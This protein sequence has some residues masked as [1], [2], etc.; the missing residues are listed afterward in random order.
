VFVSHAPHLREKARALR[1]ERD[2]TIDEIAARL[3]LSRTTVWS[4]VADLPR[5]S[6]RPTTAQERARRRGANAVKRKHAL[7]RDAAYAEA[8]SAFAVRCDEPTFRDFVCLYVGEGTKRARNTV[9]LA[10]SDP[11]VILLAHGWISAL[12][13][14]PLE[15]WLQY[16]ADQDPAVLQTYWAGLL[17]CSPGSVRLQ[18]KSNSSQ[19]RRRTWRSRYGV[20]TVRSHD[21]LL[22]ARLDAW[23]NCLRAEWRDLDSPTSGA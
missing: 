22:R 19:L 6:A 18:R 15:L 4:W 17:G 13:A 16:H 7:L 8:A 10:N 3:A 14:R 9:A 2:L 23:M 1:R 21:T 12:S 5:R 11:A 20:L